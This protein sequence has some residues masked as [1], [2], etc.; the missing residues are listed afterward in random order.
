MWSLEYTNVQNKE[1]LWILAIHWLFL[2]FSYIK[3]KLKLT[4]DS[5]P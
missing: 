4:F 1:G 3:V 5:Y 2:D